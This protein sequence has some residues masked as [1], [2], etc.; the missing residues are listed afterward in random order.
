MEAKDLV[1]VT[2]VA[3][4]CFRTRKEIAGNFFAKIQF[5]NSFLYFEAAQAFLSSTAPGT[6]FAP[7]SEFKVKI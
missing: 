7:K 4:L 2:Q 3:R 6:T 5:S 1:R